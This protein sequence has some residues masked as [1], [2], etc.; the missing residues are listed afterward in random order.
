MSDLLTV[1][2]YTAEF[3]KW[4]QMLSQLVAGQTEDVAAFP[5]VVRSVFFRTQMPFI[6]SESG[7]FGFSNY[8]GLHDSDERARQ[9]TRYKEE[10]RKYPIAGD[11]YTQAT[12]IEE[13]QNGIIDAVSCELKVPAGLLA[14]RSPKIYRK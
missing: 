3:E 1:H 8:G 4:K 12:N 13:E 11:V 9:I 14:S 5:L 7:G 6:V 2:L 10:L